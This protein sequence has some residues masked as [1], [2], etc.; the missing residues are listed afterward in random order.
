M[1]DATNVKEDAWI[2]TSCGQCYCMC[3]IKARRQNGIITEI[4]VKL[5]PKPAAANVILAAFDDVATAGH[6]SSSASS[7]SGARPSTRTVY[8]GTATRCL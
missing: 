5:L 3:G 4:T 6:P 7:A 8:V 2:P 1:A